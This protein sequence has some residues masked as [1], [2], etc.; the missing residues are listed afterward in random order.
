METFIF[1]NH[2]GREHGGVS[3]TSDIRLNSLD[4]RAQALE[5]KYQHAKNQA[6]PNQFLQ[7]D[8]NTL[9]EL[10]PS[11]SEKKFVIVYFLDK[12][13]QYSFGFK[14]KY[15]CWLIDVIDVEIVE[16]GVYCVHD[17]FLD[18]TV[19]EDLSYSVLDV[20]E[21]LEAIEKQVITSKQIRHSIHALKEAMDELNRFDFP[22][23]RLKNI[24]SNISL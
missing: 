5:L 18:I 2:I 4:V 21:F 24:I 17:L 13:L 14:T 10:P 23:S 6:N 9:V 22:N 7:W 19:N 16:D 8:E 3:Y 12:G 1:W 11:S 15:P 20:D